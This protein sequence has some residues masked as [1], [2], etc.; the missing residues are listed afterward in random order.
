V[1]NVGGYRPTDAEVALGALMR[2]HWAG[3]A[4][5]GAPTTEE[6]WPAWSPEGLASMRYLAGES[7]ATIGIR[8]SRCDFW[9]EYYDGLAP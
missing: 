3:L 5:L 6:V 8:Q 4:S 9:D 7:A 2:E 1:L